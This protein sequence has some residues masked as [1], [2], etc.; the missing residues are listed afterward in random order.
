MLF[1]NQSFFSNFV[2]RFYINLWKNHHDVNKLGL[3][4]KI[5]K[6]IL[7]TEFQFPS[8]HILI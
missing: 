4:N 3:L 7:Q 1:Q 5:L 6:P 2:L 8:N